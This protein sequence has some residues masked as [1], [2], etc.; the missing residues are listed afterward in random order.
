M[1]INVELPQGKR[2]VCG[3]WTFPQTV[4]TAC[5]GDFFFLRETTTATRNGNMQR[6]LATT[7][8][9]ARVR[10][11]E[12]VPGCLG[13]YKDCHVYARLLTYLFL[14]RLPSR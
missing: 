2:G 3:E 4:V 13:I 9:Q 11:L 7:S 1:L 12:R 8:Q 10:S 6:D 14:Y 5:S